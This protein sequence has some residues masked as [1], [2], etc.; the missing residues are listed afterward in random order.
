MFEDGS[1][2]FLQEDFR[3]ILHCINLL[4]GSV[5]T[6]RHPE[7]DCFW[8]W[9]EVY[10]PLMDFSMANVGDWVE[11]PYIIP[12]LDRRKSSIAHLGTSLETWLVESPSS[13][14]TIPHAEFD[15]NRSRNR[16]FFPLSRS[17]M[18]PNH[19]PFLIWFHLLYQKADTSLWKTCSQ[20]FNNF[21]EGSWED[22]GRQL[23]IQR[24][25]DKLL[26]RVV[27]D[28]GNLMWVHLRKEGFLL[29]NYNSQPIQLSKPVSFWLSTASVFCS[30][31]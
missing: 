14:M 26:R 2:P 9:H 15:Y 11:V 21:N 19:P 24:R 18:V 27:F 31:I 3:C 4:Q 10:E 5:L 1:F 30:S 8:S 13:G 22:W 23:E 16:T 12:S 7:V 6:S 17:S 25:C 20:I 29:G 28:E